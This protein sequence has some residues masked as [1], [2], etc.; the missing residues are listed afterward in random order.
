MK[1]A[2]LGIGTNMGDRFGNLQSAVDSLNLLPT[3]K[4]NAVSRVYETDP[5]GYSDQENFLNIAVEVSTDLTAEGLLG[6]CLGIEAGL[7]RVRT[8]KNG[9][10]V[11]DIDLLLYDTQICD[12]SMLNLPH[13]RMFEREFVL[14]PLI[15]IDFVHP[16]VD[17]EKIKSRLTGEGIRLT[18]YQIKY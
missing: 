3:T 12:T 4:V 10:R 17:R 1:K 16:L 14:R 2:Y 7:G 6:A 15:D 8:F 13:P 11:I 9:P 5:V 18:K